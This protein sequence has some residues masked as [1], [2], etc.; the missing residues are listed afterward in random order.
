MKLKDLEKKVRREARNVEHE[1]RHFLQETRRNR[2][3]EQVNV[4]NNAQPKSTS[5]PSI[6]KD[7]AANLAEQI[8]DLSFSTAPSTPTNDSKQPEWNE[9]EENIGTGTLSEINTS[10]DITDS[11]I[12]VSE[13]TF[14]DNVLGGGTFGVIFLGIYQGQAVAIKRLICQ[15]K[16]ARNEIKNIKTLLKLKHKNLLKTFGICLDNRKKNIVYST[17][18][19]EYCRN[20]NLRTQ[21]DDAKRI[22]KFFF[23]K[24]IK[25]IADAML[26]LHDC[27]IVHRDLKPENVLLDELFDIRVCDFGLCRELEA[28]AAMSYCGTFAYMAPE[29]IAQQPC[30]TKVDVWSFGVLFWEML[31]QSRPYAG[32]ISG[33][34]LLEIGKHCLATDKNS[35][36]YLHPPQECPEQIAAMINECL[37]NDPHAR[38]SFSIITRRIPFI[39]EELNYVDDTQWALLRLEQSNFS[40]TSQDLTTLSMS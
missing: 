30:S 14:T 5:T 15:D 35:S 17:I 10:I 20:G 23:I 38:P 31:T 39:E 37:L 21:V 4:E 1:V 26:Y 13:V 19:M 28:T 32:I 16:N 22:T 18:V 27:N 25:E 11:T 8:D 7:E 29:I 34:V 6:N 3:R 2:R 9:V 12:P 40:D 33:R 36:F 24:W